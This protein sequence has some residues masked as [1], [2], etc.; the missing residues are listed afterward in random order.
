VRSFLG[1]RL[2]RELLARA[3]ALACGEPTEVDGG[4]RR[5]DERAARHAHRAVSRK[6]A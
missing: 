2:E 3:F 4:N 6:G 1:S 5:E